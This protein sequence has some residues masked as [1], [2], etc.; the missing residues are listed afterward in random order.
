[1]IGV[2]G[3]TVDVRNGVV[4]LNGQRVPDPHAHYEAPLQEHT[5]P[6]PRDN[7]GPV[8]VPL[9]KL[10][11]MGDNRDRS[12]DSRWWGFVDQN[13]VEGRALIM[14]WSWDDDA[15]GLVKLRWSRFGRV[16]E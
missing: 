10:F 12:Y 4:F 9:G 13:D 6:G 16:V 3:D 11:M 7:Y 5:T 15:L 14:Y 1:V 2:A 8:K